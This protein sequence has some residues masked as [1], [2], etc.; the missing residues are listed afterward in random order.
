MCQSRVSDVSEHLHCHG[1]MRGK[2]SDVN[3]GQ[4]KFCSKTCDGFTS[5]LLC[6]SRTAEQDHLYQDAEMVS[7]RWRRKH[8]NDHHQLVQMCKTQK[9]LPP[10]ITG[11]HSAV[12]NGHRH[13]CLQEMMIGN[14]SHNWPTRRDETDE[15]R[16][17]KR[18]KH[19]TQVRSLKG[20]QGRSLRGSVSAP[21][22]VKS[23]RFATS[24]SG[25][26]SL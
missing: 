25:S 14:G 17:I 13:P 9:D 22:N 8:H 7:L 2:D 19:T 6:R 21:C 18:Q 15:R 16:E 5:K 20:F 10:K 11:R 1:S 26:S 12:L 3:K 23:A 4:G 24:T